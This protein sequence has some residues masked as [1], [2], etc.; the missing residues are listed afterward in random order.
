[1]RIVILG[2]INSTHTQRWARAMSQLGHNIHVIGIS[3]PHDSTQVEDI[4]HSNLGISYKN[5]LGT[6]SLK[7]I[8]YLS[9]WFKLRRQ[10][11]DFN[12]LFIH[13][14]FASSYGVLAWLSMFRP[15]YVSLWG[16]DIMEFPSRGIVQRKLLGIVV[17]NSR[18]VFSTS[19]IIQKKANDLYRAESHK[20]PFG[21]HT[22]LFE[23]NTVSRGD[24]IVIGTIKRLESIYGIDLLIK[25]FAKVVEQS[26]HE[27]SLIII[28]SG[29]QKKELVDLVQSLGVYSL[30]QFIDR[31]A[32]S[33]VPRNLARMDIFANLSR[34]ESFGVSVLEAS[35]AG[36]PVLAS[37]IP[38]LREVYLENETALIVKVDDLND[39]S[40][41]LLRLVED[42]SL[43][44]ELGEKG[45]E[46]VKSQYE[47]QQNV[48][49]LNS[50]YSIDFS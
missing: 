12:P 2:D 47:W 41:K 13:A 23:T 49:T 33:E 7:K 36:L 28:G 30:V 38:G 4:S 44:K 39:T 27:L 16:S 37:D 18:R 42:Y 10:I 19:E 20:I 9:A 26:N 31:I 15:Y 5:S 29:S 46:F 32:Y 24:K 45:R 21:V 17:N 25:S 48:E 8:I 11:R 1:M 3:P 34:R 40:V 43:R 50:F 35:A 6:S 14:H 22:K